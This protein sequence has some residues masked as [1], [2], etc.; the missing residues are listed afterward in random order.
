MAIK[1]ECS[2]CGFRNDLGRVFCTQCG[3]KLDLKRTSQADLEDRRDVPYG[4][5]IAKLVAWLLL[6]AVLGCIG[7]GFWAANSPAVQR[8]A[9]GA[10]QVVLKTRAVKKAIT[11]GQ[12]A[13]VDFTEAEV[14]GFL[15]GR[16][17]V[18]KLRALSVDIRPGAMDVG[19]W[20]A[21][22]PGVLANLSWF[23]RNLAAPVS[24]EMTMVFEDGEMRVLRGRVGHLPLIGPMQ[25]T[26]KKFFKDIFSD[27]MAENQVVDALAE[28]AFDQDVAH[29]K[30]GK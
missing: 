28:V 8:D 27:V 3:V 5:I 11:A 6:I 16:A 4:R 20:F 21:W 19:A 29:M 24:V 14:N 22:R 30:F 2:S 12:R 9:A 13:T 25:G 17:E 10:Q 7:L 15:A 1:I 18:R 26:A 23:P